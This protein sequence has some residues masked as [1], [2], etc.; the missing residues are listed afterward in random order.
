MQISAAL[1]AAAETPLPAAELRQVAEL[2]RKT[3]VESLLLP[4]LL[5]LVI[6]IL[7]AR[8]FADL[9]RRL[10]QPNA[11]GEIFA[12]LLLGPS[13]LGWLWPDVWNM[14]FHPQVPGTAAAMQPIY[15]ATL[16]WIFTI[17]AQVGLVLLMFLIGLE[18]DF[19]HLTVRGTSAVAISLTGIV[20]PFTLGSLLAGAIYP[21]LEPHQH[22]GESVPLLGFVFFLG[23]ALSI[24]ALPILGRI[25][26]EL[27]ITRTRLGAVTISAAAVDDAMGWIILAT[28]ATFV[29]GQFELTGVVRM[30]GATLAFAAAMLLILGPLLRL[31]AGRVVRSGQGEIGVTSL[32][33]LFGM[34][35]VASICTNMIGIFAIF[36]A[37]LL[38]AV[39]SPAEEFRAAVTRRLYDM[40]VT[41]FL[42]IFF[43]YTGLRTKIGT[44]N[45]PTLWLICAAVCA[46]AFI[47]KFGGCGIAARF[48]GFNS[49]E[50]LCIGVMMNTRALMELVVINVGYELGV[51]PDSVFCMLVIM[52]LLTTIITTP[53]LVRFKAGTEIEPY[54]TNS[55]FLLQRRGNRGDEVA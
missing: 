16:H 36:G 44:L 29:R 2:L 35:F 49:R 28:V 37:F 42:P 24:T 15:D 41:F 52:A 17:L 10:G 20:L 14:L 39:L 30:L 6:I 3:H 55:G 11:V 26:M 46:A 4:V 9:F 32:A 33:L 22:T 54:I 45:S 38:G 51:I 1:L 13:F 8:I 12:G 43:T 7:T 47:G 23:T 40:V 18:F 34:I 5:Q 25:M 19:S 31:W 21:Y 53:M 48:T 27:G 50:S